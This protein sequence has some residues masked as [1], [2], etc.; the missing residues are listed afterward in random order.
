MCFST[1]NHVLKKNLVF[2]QKKS[3][4][5]Y[6]FR[7]VVPVQNFVYIFIDYKYKNIKILL[8]LTKRSNYI[9]RA[10]IRAQSF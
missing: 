8:K 5:S 6:E 10:L 9:I 7:R 3:N 1:F 4:K 2:K